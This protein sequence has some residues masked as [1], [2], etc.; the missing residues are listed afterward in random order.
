M[1]LPSVEVPVAGLVPVVVP[2]VAPVGVP[3]VAVG[4]VVVGVPPDPIAG[5]Q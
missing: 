5:M 1:V 3:P 2:A 4:P